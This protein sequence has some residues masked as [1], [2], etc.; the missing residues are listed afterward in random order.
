MAFADDQLSEEQLYQREYLV[1]RVDQDLFWMEKAQWPFRNP[2]FYF[3]W[4]GDSLDPSPYIAL[5]Y[6]PLDQRMRAFTLHLK[7]VPNAIAQIRGNLAM[8]MPRTWL[9]LG[10]DGFR[11]L[12]RLF[13][14]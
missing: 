8:P 13:P 6:A 14:G 1:S 2:E 3:G 4:M 11:W 7:N 9:Q 12:C 5:D 10:I